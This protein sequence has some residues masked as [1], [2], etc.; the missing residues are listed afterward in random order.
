MR[1]NDSITLNIWEKIFSFTNHARR[2]AVKEF[3]WDDFSTINWFVQAHII[4]LIIKLIFPILFLI[5]LFLTFIFYRMS[6]LPF[7]ESIIK[8]EA[9]VSILNYVF[10]I[11]WIFCILY[12]FKLIYNAYVDYKND[13]LVTFKDWIYI[14]NKEG[15]FHL[16]QSKVPFSSVHTIRATEQNFFHAILETWTLFIKTTWNM[17]DINFKYCKNVHIEAKK[18]QDLHFDYL[19]KNDVRKLFEEKDNHVSE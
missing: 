18:L 9:W 13:F 10:F 5:I 6:F 8:N 1:K 19:R 15:I 11:P 12:I 4:S 3:L 2:K 17:E 16:A 14:S 7:I